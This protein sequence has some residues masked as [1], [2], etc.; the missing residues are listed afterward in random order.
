MYSTVSD[1]ASRQVGARP[2]QNAH[3]ITEVQFDAKEWN[4]LMNHLQHGSAQSDA[5]VWVQDDARYRT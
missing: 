2:F 4:R 1:T 3:A 5:C